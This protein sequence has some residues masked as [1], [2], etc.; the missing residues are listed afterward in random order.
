MAMLSE[1]VTFVFVVIL[2]ITCTTALPAA[3]KLG[4]KLHHIPLVC[5]TYRA[6]ALVDGVVLTN[7]RSSLT[8]CLDLRVEIDETKARR[9]TVTR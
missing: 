1:V 9:F 5:V 6:C 2:L 8:T 3:G 4:A 7:L